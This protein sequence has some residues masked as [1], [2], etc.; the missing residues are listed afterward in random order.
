M[1]ATRDTLTNDF[2]VEVNMIGQNI[3]P[4]GITALL[5]LQPLKAARTGDP[6]R[7]GS[8]DAVHEKGFWSHEVS[9]QD[10]VTECR[11]HQLNC[12][13]DAIA[14]H[15]DALR[16]NGVEKIYFNYTLTSFL[17]LMNVCFKS[18]TLTKLAAIGADLHVS[19]F[20]CFN[21]N[22]E[23]WQEDG[24]MATASQENGN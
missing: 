11:D 1:R 8:S 17:G 24:S 23:I 4:D 19:C 21:P 22:H 14:P 12:L 2:S 10:D 13:A 18:E 3:D 9:S 15:V 7:N 20:D 16:E 6:R 5:G